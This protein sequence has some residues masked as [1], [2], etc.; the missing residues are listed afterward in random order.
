[1]NRFVVVVLCGLTVT[2]V[3]QRPAP[4]FE[5]A[6]IKPNRDPQ[7]HR[8]S[9][10]PGGQLIVTGYRLTDIIRHAYDTNLERL[11]GVPDWASREAFDITARPARDTIGSSRQTMEMLQT[12]LKER[13]RLQAHVERREMPVY[14]MRVAR[15]GRL[16]PQLR[17]S[18]IDCGSFVPGRSEAPEQNAGP[19]CVITS[20]ST[21]V[22]GTNRFRLR[23][24]SM[25]RLAA[26]F[27]IF[28]RRPVIDET[29]LSGLFDAEIEF[30]LAVDGSVP[31]DGI[32]VFT[33]TEEQ[34]GLRLESTRGSVD[35]VVID[36]VE[37]PT[38]D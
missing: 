3:A 14:A 9:I 13:F 29:G 32:T 22:A 16:G 24:R 31:Q 38:P 2:V 4:S 6:S 33:A 1:M 10:L 30:A 19:Q 15:P 21:K 11:I 7:L 36:H 12:L 18:D 35:V 28:T 25:P 26:D 5:V 37:R 23:G 8:F 27:Q 34:L 20:A 17:P